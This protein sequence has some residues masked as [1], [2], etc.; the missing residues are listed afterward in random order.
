ME[1]KDGETGFRMR[2]I[3]LFLCESNKIKDDTLEP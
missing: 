2:R 3:F 1:G